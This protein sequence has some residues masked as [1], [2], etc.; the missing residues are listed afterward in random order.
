MPETHDELSVLRSEVL[1]LREE[2]QLLQAADASTTTSTRRGMLRLAGAAVLG[3]GAL[4]ADHTPVAADNGIVNTNQGV[5]TTLTHTATTGFHFKASDSTYATNS[6]VIQVSAGTQ[7]RHCIR[8]FSNNITSTVFLKNDGIGSALLATS[9]SLGATA[10]FLNNKGPTIN[11][12]PAPGKP[13]RQPSVRTGRNTTRRSGRTMPAPRV[14]QPV[15]PLGDL[16]LAAAHPFSS[17]RL[18]P[19]TADLLRRTA[20]RAP[21]EPLPATF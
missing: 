19:P 15:H 21:P 3:A 5:T 18:P 17:R 20:G 9:N 14:A 6:E 1:A 13:Q 2:L 8:A 12:A 4:L 11:L 7:S 10:T 16:R